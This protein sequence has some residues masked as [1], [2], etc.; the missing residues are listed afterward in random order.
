[1]GE[2]TVRAKLSNAFDIEFAARGGATAPRSVEVDATVDT[3]A[4]RSVIS[5]QI[6]E[7]LGLRVLPGRPVTLADGNRVTAGRAEG[8]RF[9]ILGRVTQEEALVLRSEGNV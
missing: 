4:V 9:E 5:R 1:M 8:I 2:V 7:D 3:G 6:A